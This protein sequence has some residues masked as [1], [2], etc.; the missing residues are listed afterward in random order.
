MNHTYLLLLRTE[1]TNTGISLCLSCY[2]WERAGAGLSYVLGAA[3][4][5][6]KA[7]GLHKHMLL[8]SSSRSNLNYQSVH[9]CTVI[10][11]N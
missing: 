8:F 3:Q 9:L 11:E 7:Q 1:I 5:T 2:N 10:Y 6:S 4:T